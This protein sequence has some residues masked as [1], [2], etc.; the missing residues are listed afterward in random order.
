MGGLHDIAQIERSAAALRQQIDAGHHADQ[1][2]GIAVADRQPGAAAVAELRATTCQLSPTSSGSISRR[3]SSAGALRSAMRMTPAIYPVLGAVDDACGLGLG[4]DQTDFLVAD[5]PPVVADCPASPAPAG[6]SGPEARPA[7]PR[8][9]SPASAARRGRPRPRGRAGQAAWAQARPRSATD[10]DDH[11][12]AAHARGC[13]TIPVRPN[14]AAPRKASR[15]PAWR[16]KRHD[17]TPTSV[18]PIW[19]EDRM[20]RSSARRS[21]MVA[22][23]SPRS[24]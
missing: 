2:V 7:A 1:V 19:T 24:P 5:A 14:A 22:P 4:D 10:G 13:A 11:D 23:R 6:P 18:I 21:A 16:R 17:S 3:G 9:R 20:A 15:V 8:A 12:H